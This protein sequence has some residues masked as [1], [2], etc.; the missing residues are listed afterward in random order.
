MMDQK[1]NLRDELILLSLNHH[2]ARNS[3][4]YHWFPEC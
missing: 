3:T 4:D 1:T 2:N